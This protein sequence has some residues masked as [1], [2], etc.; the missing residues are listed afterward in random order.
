MFIS[1]R[2][3]LLA[4]S[5]LLTCLAVSTYAEQSGATPELVYPNSRAGSHSAV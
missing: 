5:V 4:I 3:A 1:G 2:R